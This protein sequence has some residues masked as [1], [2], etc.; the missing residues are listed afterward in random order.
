MAWGKDESF[1]LGGG[2]VPGL[3]SNH[4]TAINQVSDPEFFLQ[5]P[6]L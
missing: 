2:E 1:G 6:H 3:D 5:L 4:S